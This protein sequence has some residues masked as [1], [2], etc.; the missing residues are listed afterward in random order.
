VQCLDDKSLDD[1]SNYI[2]RTW[3]VLEIVVIF[4]LSIFLQTI[5]K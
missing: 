5:R 3:S 4:T 2:F 1:K